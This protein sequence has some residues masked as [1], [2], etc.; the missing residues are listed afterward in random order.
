M[1]RKSMLVHFKE[2]RRPVATTG[3]LSAMSGR[4]LPSTVDGL[5]L[6]VEKGLVIKI[7]GSVWAEAGN[8]K[9]NQYSVIPFLFPLHRVYV[10]FV[11]ALHLHGI[12]ERA[13]KAVMLAWCPLRTKVF[14]T[15]LGS[16]HVHRMDP[17]F[18]DGFGWHKETGS[19][20]IAEPEKALVDCLYISTRR[21]KQFCRFP[22]LHFPRS[23]RFRR[24]REWVE[25]I[26]DWRTRSY[27]GKRLDMLL[28]R[29]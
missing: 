24:A 17:L 1:K 5:N 26:S 6:L 7:R 20:L 8:E 27:V 25:R 12:V 3:E 13:P 9:L 14:H 18:F 2:L 4:S 21:G 28:R 10:S 11:S 22:R 16:Y 15:P 19:F 23:F 29:T